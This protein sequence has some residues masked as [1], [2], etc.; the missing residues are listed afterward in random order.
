MTE[1]YAVLQLSQNVGQSTIKE[2]FQSLYL[3][4]DDPA[5]RKQLEDAYA[6]LGDPTRRVAYDDLLK[7][8]GSSDSAVKVAIEARNRER[9][10]EQA[11]PASNKLS[12]YQT[13]MLPYVGQKIGIN[14]EDPS[15]L[16]LCPLIAVSDEFFTVSNKGMK[17]HF[18]YRQVLRVM[19]G[20]AGSK[21]TTGKYFGVE[22]RLFIEIFHLVVYKGA[23]GF[24]M[25]IP[26]GDFG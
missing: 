9:Q 2:S 23:I 20:D 11:Q 8:E 15:K 12:S 26:L 17:V 16:Q 21:L 19:E 13:L 10:M 22:A 5:L 14:I 3:N 24:G 25:S 7:K 18:P 6:V 1:L 4:T